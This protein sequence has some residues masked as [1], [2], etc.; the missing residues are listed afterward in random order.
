M[1]I[2]N[3]RI[4][5]IKAHYHSNNID[6]TRPKHVK[7][8]CWVQGLTNLHP[9]TA[10]VKAFQKVRYTTHMLQ[11]STAFL[12]AQSNAVLP[13]MRHSLPQLPYT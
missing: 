10:H 12:Q 8:I 7:I 9:S 11:H 6:Q 4:V 13:S 1:V 2:L 3:V 5:Q